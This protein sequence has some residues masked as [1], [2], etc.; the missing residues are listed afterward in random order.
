MLKDGIVYELINRVIIY[1]SRVLLLWSLLFW[2]EIIFSWCL[3][4]YVFINVKEKKIFF[5]WIEEEFLIDYKCTFMFI[6][7]YVF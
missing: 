2:L 7:R 3:S 6:K 5:K 1:F 4:Y